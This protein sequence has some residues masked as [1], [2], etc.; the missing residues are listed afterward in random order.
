MDSNIFKVI[1]EQ[2]NLFQKQNP[3]PFHS[4]MAPWKDVTVEELRI[5]LALTIN[6]GHVRKCNVKNYWSMD[7]LL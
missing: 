5:F 1:L 4:N 2:T 7:P 3:D 6:M